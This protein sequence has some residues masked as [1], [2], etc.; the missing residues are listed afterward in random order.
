MDKNQAIGLGLIAVILFTYFG[1]F[2]EPYYEETEEQFE[3]EVASQSANQENRQTVE[4][5]EEVE[6]T[7]EDSVSDSLR[8]AELNNRFGF[9]ATSAQGEEKEYTLEN[10][11]IVIKVSSKGGEISYAELKGHRT[12]NDEPLVLLD[13]KSSDF[14]MNI[15]FLFGKVN[16]NDLYFESPQAQVQ[17]A[18][19]DTLKLQ[20]IVRGDDNRSLTLDYVLPPSGHQIHKSIRTINLEN[21]L[22]DL[23]ITIEWQNRLKPVERDLKISRTKTNFHYRTYEKGFQSLSASSEFDEKSAEQPVHWIGMKQKFFTT[24][25][26]NRSGSGFRAAEFSKSFDE[27]DT[28]IEKTMNAKMNFNLKD[29]EQHLTYFFGPNDYKDLKAVAADFD[30]NLDLGW[31][32]LLKWINKYIVINV[33]HFLEKY[34]GNYGIIIALLALFIKIILLPLSYKSYMSM[35]KMRVVKPDID[36][37]KEKYGDDMQKVQTAQ[38][39]LY[40]KAGVN[41]LSGCVPVL[42]Q[43]PILFAMFYFFPNSVEL[44]QESFLWAADL[45]TYDAIINLPF[46][47]PL[48]GSHVSLFTILMTASTIVYTWSN[49]QL[50]AQSGPMKN[51]AYFL[52][53]TFMVFLNSFP[54]GLTFYY[55]VSNIITFG[56]QEI[57]RRFVDEDKVKKIMEE[58][59]K[60]NANKK[61][62]KFQLRLEEAMK[63]AEEDKKKKSNKKK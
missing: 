29:G 30:E 12:Y 31:I 39:E 27:N 59:K 51:I 10:D 55:F 37:I 9:F 18:T 61:K 7:S 24:G 21:Q 4:R 3:Q 16:I 40:R 44:R 25:L 54:A 62:S 5:L 20:L 42:L 52:P 14:N 34:I 57:I 36:E 47:I 15:P 8:N 53:I 38:M 23:P 49:Q 13:D 58:N 50:T 48:Y 56:Q 6:E 43:M 60:K 45:S 35:A 46:N 33:F 19:G 2:A 1:F 17:K 22:A 11:D 28:T 26:V 32:F 63:A 41:P